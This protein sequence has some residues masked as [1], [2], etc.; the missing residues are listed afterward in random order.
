MNLESRLPE[1]LTIAVDT[2]FRRELTLTVQAAARIAPRTIAVQIYRSH[3][4][5]EV[6]TA[7]FEEHHSLQVIRDQG[8]C[9]D[10][11]IRP[12]RPLS[13]DLSPATMARDLLGLSDAQVVPLDI[14]L[15]DIGRF[16]ECP[17][18]GQLKLPE[19]VVWNQKK[20]KWKI[21]TLD[22]T[23]VGHF[24]RAD[25]ARLFGQGFLGGLKSQ[26]LNGYARVALEARKL[27]QFVA[28]GERRDTHPV[29]QYLRRGASF[30]AVRVGV[31]DT[32]LPFGSASLDHLAQTFVGL[33][34]CDALNDEDKEDMVRA[35]QDRPAHALA[36]AA[37]DAVVTLLVYEQMVTTDRAV[38]GSLG[39]PGEGVPPFHATAGA[40]VAAILEG[41][42]RT[43][44]ATGS[45]ELAS[46]TSLREL[47]R[48]GGIDLFTNEPGA[49]KFG[50]LT[51]TV[52]G[53]LLLNRSPTRLW[54]ASSCMLADVDMAS[55]YGKIT[56]GMDVYWG[57]PVIL[58]PGALGMKL[59]QAIELVERLCD[60]DGWIVR[61]T[62]SILE[63]PNALIPSTD[64]AVTGENYD[65]TKRRQRRRDAMRQA[66][67]REAE[68]EPDLRRASGR[69]YA[70][71]VESGVVCAATWRVIRVLPPT[72]RRQYEGLTVDSL[73][74]YPRAWAARNGREYDELVHRHQ[75]GELSWKQ[76]LDEEAGA[77]VRTELL[78]DSYVTLRYPLR[79]Y[80]VQMMRLR[81]SARDAHGNGSATE[82]AFKLITNSTYGVLAAPYYCVNNFVAANVITA[83][84]RAGAYVSTQALNAVQTITDGCTYRRDQIPAAR[85]ADCLLVH[86]DYPIRRAEEGDG[87]TF[88]E[89][90]SVP[91]D[92]AAFNDWYRRH[93]RWFFECGSVLDELVS[94]HELVHKRCGQ[95]GRL[96]FDGL[97]VDGAG[98][99]VKA[100]R[101]E[102][103]RY[104]S[105][106]FKARSYGKSS[107]NELEQWVLAVYAADF[108]TGPAPVTEDAELLSFEQA[109]LEVR[110]ALYAGYPEVLFPLGFK[111]R[112]VLNYRIIKA[113]AFVFNN[114]EQRVKILKQIH[115]FEDKYG[116][117]LEVLAL[118]RDYAGRK[119]GSVQALLELIYKRIRSGT[120]SL[121]GPLN[122]GKLSGWLV[123]LLRSRREELER[124]RDQAR[125][126]LRESMLAVG[127]EP[128]L[129][130]TSI[131]I[132]TGEAE[133]IHPGSRRLEFRAPLILTAL[134]E[135][136]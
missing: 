129:Y 17:R 127:S 39:L 116:A 31:R 75:V 112:K 28:L 13:A 69:L 43:S 121:S 92:G 26:S 76:I 11:V 86:S 108:L 47:M 5:S 133:C 126:A 107:K 125:Q 42:T 110:H 117:G 58:E 87:I 37:S 15:L 56:C 27:H 101:D 44:A 109:A 50:P 104:C 115:K 21:P 64:G 113:S 100:I 128:A 53:G 40:R 18:L 97:A 62:G 99:Y 45:S 122:T 79:T 98:N 94:I 103:G 32:C 49:S 61:V 46:K 80:A 84:A 136:T 78:D 25:I 91:A 60:P 67:A 7:S 95:S 82:Q 114:P 8:H 6:A 20:Q 48:R 134:S 16:A 59:P 35:F 19:G 9:D 63:H 29:L 93:V 1:C 135:K 4:L 24:L 66:I 33:P 71:R 30:L 102:D 52:H 131:V 74:F 106:E 3:V 34:K 111:R 65:R 118:R 55:C 23:L 54:Y 96:N 77:L 81:Q 70:E 132:T 22:L 72:L 68:E 83:T 10:F 38:R 12:A 85:F 124:R 123:T 89:P 73:V 41:T 51:A 88:L 119:Q 36:Y 57:R 120:S 14:G 130:D 90:S 105:I 2:E